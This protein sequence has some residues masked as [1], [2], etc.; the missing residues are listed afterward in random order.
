[1]LV[2]ESV[3]VCQRESKCVEEG[4]RGSKNLKKVG[5]SNYERC[6]EK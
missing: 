6:T 4:E 5:E 3:M 1:M 2:S